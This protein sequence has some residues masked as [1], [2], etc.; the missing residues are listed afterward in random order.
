MIM[1]LYRE[2]P[3]DSTPKLL[4]PIFGKGAKNTQ[5][6]K[7]ILFNKCCW[8]NWISTC[9]RMNLDTFMLHK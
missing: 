3:E 5:W 8:E 4:D 6:G 7:N 1:I 2:N 9:R